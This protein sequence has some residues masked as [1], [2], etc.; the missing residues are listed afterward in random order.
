[1]GWLNTIQWM[2]LMAALL[3]A[4]SAFGPCL[5]QSAAEPRISTARADRGA[6]FLAKIRLSDPDYRVILMACLKEHELNLLLSRELP[7]DQIPLLVKGLL[8]QLGTVFPGEDL[9]VVAFRPIVPLRAAAV[10]RF[11]SQTGRTDFSAG[12]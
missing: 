10:A 11:D 2:V 4:V 9:S 1:M 12:P 8:G 3:T 7:E 5:A 6:V